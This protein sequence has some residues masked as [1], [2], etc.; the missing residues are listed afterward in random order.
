MKIDPHTFAENFITEDHF[1]S[2]ARARGVEVGAVDATPGAGAYLRH[3]AFSLSAQAVVE[4]GTGS[5]VGS[6]WLLDGMLTSGTLTSIDDEMEHTQIAKLAF[7]EAD[8]PQTRYRLITNSVL[9]VISKLTDRA[10]DLVVLRHNPEDLAFVIG[11]AQRILRSGGALVIDNYFGGSKVNDP[12]QRDP[13]TVALR[14]AGKIIKND[15][16]HWVSVLISSGDG[17]LVATKL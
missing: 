3:L 5:G 16:E 17:L 8:I 11:E 2:Q 1:K 14:D 15:T 13:K 7:A 4:V 10:Y 6:L 12:A 9:D